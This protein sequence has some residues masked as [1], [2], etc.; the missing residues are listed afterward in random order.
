MRIVLFWRRWV[1]P[2]YKEIIL[3][4][5]DRCDLIVSQ[6]SELKYYFGILAS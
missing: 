1:A 4:I 2:V 6:K 5:V 3:I